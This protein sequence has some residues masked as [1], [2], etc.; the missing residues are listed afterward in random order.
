MGQ[1]YKLGDTEV[2]L[3]EVRKQ[4]EG[5][6]GARSG[7]PFLLLPISANEVL[8]LKVDYDKKE[9]EVSDV[10]ASS[11]FIKGDGKNIEGNIILKKEKKAYQFFSRQLLEQV[12]LLTWDHSIG[13]MIRRAGRLRSMVSNLDD[14]IAY[15]EHQY[16]HL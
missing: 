16:R 2:F 7:K 1:L 3:K 11:F 12:V 4:V 10:E 9:N 8:S 13:M 14:G 15:R 6:P 5:L